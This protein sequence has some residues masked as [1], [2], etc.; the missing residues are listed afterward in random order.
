MRTWWLVRKVGRVLRIVIGVAPPWLK[1][2][3]Q[4]FAV[5][6][7]QTLA[8]ALGVCRLASPV[9]RVAFRVVLPPSLRAL[10]QGLAVIRCQTLAVAL[11][12]C[13]LASRVSRVA[14]GVALPPRPR[15]L[16]F[17]VPCW[18]GGWRADCTWHLGAI[19]DGRWPG[20]QQA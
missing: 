17:R 10:I 7:C 6:R 12:V 8:V 18:C 13:R 14:V 16:I 2:L 1:A 19:G 20:R 15:A 3:A 5:F 11:G 9:L 4:G